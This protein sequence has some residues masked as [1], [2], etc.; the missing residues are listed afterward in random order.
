MDAAVAAVRDNSAVLHDLGA[1]VVYL[2]QELSLPGAALLRTI[3]ERA[4]VTVVA[5]VT[6]A[7]RADAGVAAV[8]ER[9]GLAL[10][11][12]GRVDVPHATAVVSA[13]DPD[14]EVRAAVRMLMDAL[15]EGVPLERMAVL[16]GAAEPYARLVHEQLD[17]AGIPHNGAA[18]RTLAESV[19]GRSLLGVLALPDRDFHRHDVMTLLAGAPIWYADRPVP[20]ARWERISRRAGVVRGTAQWHDRLDRHACALERELAEELAVPDREPRPD[21]YEHELAATR[22]LD[23]F[24]AELR[25]ALAAGA[26]EDASWRDLAEWARGLVHDYLGR[27]TRRAVWP[28]PEQQ[29]ADKVEAALERL[30]G[31]D[32]V[33]PA[34]GLDVFRRTLELELDADLGRVGRLGDG[35]LMGHVSLGLGLDLDRVFV[36]GLAEGTFPARVRDDSLLPDVDRRVTEGALPLRAARVDDDH[37]RLLAALAATRD[38][39]VLLFPRGDLRRTTERMPS[40]FLLDT[41]E[42]LTGTRHYADELGGIDEPWFR[43]VPSFAAGIARVRFPATAQEHRLHAL[44]ETV[45]RGTPSPDDALPR[46]DAALRRGLECALARGSAGFTRFD[47]NLGGLEIPSP[48]GPEAVVSAT[49]L[50]R[51]AISPFDYLMEHVLRVE[52]PELPEEVYEL[53]PLDRGSLVHDTLDAF[54]REVLARD[55]GPPAPGAPWTD[56]DRARLHEL[57]EEWCDRYEALGI[58]GRRAFWDRDRRRILADLDRFLS[59]DTE[60]RDE[61]ELTTLAT[62]LSFGLPRS[63]QPAIEVPLSD[64]R[65]LRF[66]GAADRVDRSR[67][68]ALLVIDYKTGRSFSVGEEGDP[69]AAGTKLQLPV[70]ALAARAAFGTA[71]TPVVAAYW[72]VSTRG[73]FRWAEVLLDARTQERFDEVLRTIVD[74]IE[75][76]VFPC[77]ARP[78]RLV[79][80]PVA[81]LRRPRRTRHA[82]PLPRVGAQARRAG[83]RRLSRARARAGR[84]PRRARARRDGCVMTAVQEQLGLSFPVDEDTATREA[85]V[86]DLDA[87]LFV[88]AGAGSGKTQSLVDRVVALVTR[89][90]VPMREIVAVTF[91]EKAAAEL[92]DRIRRELERHAITGDPLA[93]EALD[94]LDAA[95]V[96]TLHSFAQRLL[97]EHPI[98]AGLP[99]RVEVLDDIASQ[100]TFEERWTRFIDR[101]LDDPALE[102]ALLLALNA[103]TGLAT[104]RTI[105]L[106]CNANWDLVAERMGP[107]PDPPPLA[108]A[109]LLVALDALGAHADACTDPDDKL[110]G[111]LVELADWADRLRRAP[112]EYE[113]LRLLTEAAPKFPTSSGRKGNWPAPHEVGTVR[114]A[115]AAVRDLCASVAK[116]VTEATVRRLAWEIAQ[117]TLREA[118][119]RRRSGRLEFH[120]LLVLSRAVL[121]DPRHGWDVRRRLRARY[122]RLLLDE[123]QDTDPIQCDLAALLASADPQARDRRWDELLVDPGR[124]FVVG[125]PKQSI[126]RF[127]RADIAAFLRAPRRVRRGTAAPHPQLPHDPAGDRVREPRVPRPHRRRGGVTTG[128][129]PARARARARDHRSRRR[130]PRCRRARR[131]TAR[132]RAAHTRGR[133]RGGDD[134]H[135]TR[136][137]LDGRA[138]RSRRR[139]GLGRV[140]PRRHRGAVTRAHVARSPRGRA[141]RRG[142]PV[143]RRD[144]VARLQHA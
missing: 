11:P 19:L 130:A 73:D 76:G 91:T 50:E 78:A 24:V 133:R 144:V 14:D 80:A 81:Q 117:F 22:D 90:G 56:A 109:D 45:D 128:V 49:R 65:T 111:A 138:A 13:S 37:R 129:R 102:R 51:W 9:L 139:R 53:S 136:G 16:Y 88:E 107:E 86:A 43:H 113:Q 27:D 63:A 74:G 85:I 28:E 116:T 68:G 92:R 119:E 64:G 62:E 21:W 82:R 104:L 20:S 106:A 118:D 135:R 96:S 84:R 33:E 34:P 77:R 95:A 93:R 110:L 48:A 6:G 1:L 83:A 18:V 123:F 140:P 105:A 42:A 89:G 72:F 35:V 69:T 31:L 98:E 25:G 57:A 115:V 32:A 54:L 41:V 142:N 26:R 131:R 15:V 3:S 12:A 2:P 59:A 38:A 79:A 120:D 97:T 100:V 87:T 121:R 30:A 5:G 143:P 103:D 23:A 46:R 58:T 61:H 99:P 112:D 4:P 141:R 114:G 101:V 36:C 29:A 125:D 127:R 122:T 44:L 108:A 60:L 75:H 94:E 8:V 67:S 39:R 17:A 124:L 134:Q 47:G 10:A 71:S 66:R 52:I 132:R 126:Y 137:G 70:Y 55:G 40:R 7:P